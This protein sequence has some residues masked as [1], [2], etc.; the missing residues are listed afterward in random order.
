MNNYHSNTSFGQGELI[1]G[2]EGEPASVQPAPTT[3]L[4]RRRGIAE[5]ILGDTVDWQDETTGYLDCPGQDLHTTPDGPK[6]CRIKI[7]GAP[8]I[9]CFHQS[10]SEEIDDV[11]QQLRAAIFS[12]DSSSVETKSCAKTLSSSSRLMRSRP[13]KNDET[14]G[15]KLAAKMGL[16]QILTAFPAPVESWTVNSPVKILA[17]PSDHWRQL[18]TTLFHPEDVLWIGREVWELSS[19]DARFAIKFRRACDWLAVKICPGKFTCPSIFTNGAHSRSN[20]NVVRR[21]YLVVESDLLSKA[22]VGAVFS[23]IRQFLTLRAIVDTAGKSLHGWFDFPDKD[24]EDELRVILPA[25]GCD[26]ALFKASQPCRLPG[27]LRDGRFQRLLFL[28]DCKN[29][30]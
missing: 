8:T 26:A 17:G 14:A 7:D 28:D 24:V 2:Q 11:N 5:K 29:I 9:S 4:D 6:D 15:L 22:E 23:W 10:C 16:A 3:C 13:V 30:L 27:G 25:L 20:A 19:N 1:G 18:I 12:A 21:A